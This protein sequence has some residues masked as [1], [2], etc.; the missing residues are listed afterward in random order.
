METKLVR[1]PFDLELAERI[2]FGNIVG[3][4]VTQGG[5]NVCIMSWYNKGDT[6]IV[7]LVYDD[8]DTK[9]TE[10]YYNNGINPNKQN[11]D[12]FLEVPEY[13]TFKVG[14]VIYTKGDNEGVFIY[15][16]FDID[17]FMLKMYFCAAL[18]VNLAMIIFDGNLNDDAKSND[19]RLATE[20]EKQKLIDALK[21]SDDKRAKVYLKQFF[22][23][24]E[25]QEFKPFDKVLVR[26]SDDEKW[27]I[28]LFKRYDEEENYPYICFN[29]CFKQC[30][31]YNEQTAH[32]LGTNEDFNFS[33]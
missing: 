33:E 11:E 4:V 27:D 29:E 32:L 12:I 18:V 17:V 31:P 15:T 9:H 21:G 23:I 26:D 5:E 13:M 2:Q 8:N 3:R 25:K 16:G 24:E 14:D 30:I 28:N 19:Y 22:G 6:P 1:V 20:E 7:G 10:Y